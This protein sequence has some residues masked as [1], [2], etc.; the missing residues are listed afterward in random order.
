MQMTQSETV[1]RGNQTTRGNNRGSVVEPN[2]VYQQIN[3]AQNNKSQYIQGTSY[4][5]NPK[6]GQ[7]TLSQG[8]RSV[9]Y[10]KIQGL[11]SS[12]K[13]KEIAQS[14]QVRNEKLMYE[15][16]RGMSS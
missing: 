7:Q 15:L 13:L 1:P 16:Q 3:R 2:A 10:D 5:R 8:K 12:S 14:S 9:D 11:N 6:Q 4:S